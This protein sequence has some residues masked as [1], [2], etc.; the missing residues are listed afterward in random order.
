M[1]IENIKWDGENMN[2]KIVSKNSILLIIGNL[3]F[4]TGL[5]ISNKN[6]GILIGILGESLMGLSIAKK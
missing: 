4:L 2:I 6:L 1:I 5:L 3:L